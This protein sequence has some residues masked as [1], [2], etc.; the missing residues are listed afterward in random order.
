[1]YLI[2]NQILTTAVCTGFCISCWHSYKYREC[3]R[4]KTNLYLFRLFLFLYTVVT[5]FAL[6]QNLQIL[7]NDLYHLQKCKIT[8]YFIAKITE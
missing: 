2:S 7:C 1:M 8:F 3:K 4:K 5:C 6:R